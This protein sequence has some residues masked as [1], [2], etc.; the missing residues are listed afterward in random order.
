MPKPPNWTAEQV[1]KLITTP[2]ERLKELENGIKL[3]SLVRYRNW[4]LRSFVLLRELEAIHGKE[5]IDAIIYSESKIDATQIAELKKTQQTKESINALSE[6]ERLKARVSYLQ[7]LT[8]EL[9]R[10]NETRNLIAA[11]LENTIRALEP[12]AYEPLKIPQRKVKESAVAV[13]SCWH[14]GEVVKP[15][16]VNYL[17]EYNL[18][19]FVKRLQYLIEKVIKFTTVN[20][21]NHTFDEICLLFTGDM[22][23][24]IIHD[25]LIE[26]NDLTITQQALLGAFVTAQAV[27]DIAAHFPRVRILG[28]VGNHGRITPKKYFKNKQI[29]SWD[30]VFYYA[31]KLLLARQKNI[32][33]FL[34]Q[35][36]I[37]GIEIKGHKFL[38][39]HGD[40][41]RGWAGIPFYGLNKASYKFMHIYA[42]R[43]EFYRYFVSSHYH[44]K[45]SLQ[46]GYGEQILNGSLKG[47]DEYSLN[48]GLASPPYQLLFGVHEKYGKTWELSINTQFAQEEIKQVRYKIDYLDLNLLNEIP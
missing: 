28:I 48:A 14:I 46:F 24:G 17:N 45:V 22:V 41:I 26:T 12:V 27:R 30:F 15:E 36:P 38:V 29:T 33:F 37:A 10:E 44:N 8:K 20:M 31:L 40:Q 43:N 5:A 4:F 19:I 16:Q 39:F 47:P 34:P 25:E 3:Q 18:D 11:T 35:S 32:E 6:V 21:S 42:H 13:F 2:P 7:K 9:L 1:Y 23:S